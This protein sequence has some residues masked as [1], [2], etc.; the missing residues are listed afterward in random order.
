MP[1]TVKWEEDEKEH[2]ARE[3]EGEKKPKSEVV[4]GVLVL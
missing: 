3:R 4:G 1:H 2:Q